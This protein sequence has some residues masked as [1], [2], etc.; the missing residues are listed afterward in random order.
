MIVSLSWPVRVLPQVQTAGQFPLDDQQFAVRYVGPTHALHIHDYAGL[1]RVG[2]REYGLCPGDLTISPAGVESA[3]HLPRAGRH[4][5][6]H[7]MQVARGRGGRGGSEA[8]GE[9]SLPLHVRL[10]SQ[11]AL[12]ID[13]VKHISWLFGQREGSAPAVL[14]QAGASAALQ[15]LLLWLS[16]RAAAPSSFASQSRAELALDRVVAIVQG[17]FQ[18]PLRMDELAAEVEVSQNYLAR[19]FRQRFG[20]TIPHYLLLRRIDHA[21]YL[22]RH[23]NMAVAAVARRVGLPDPQHF[24]KQFR[25]HVGQSPSTYRQQGS[26]AAWHRDMAGVKEGAGVRG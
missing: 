9:F 25:Q 5:C 14:A 22:L 18:Q 15:E 12:A 17:R 3:Y 2:E 11:L 26:F 10:G 20:M 21:Q 1:W 8:E 13:R 23:T 19:C 16:W 24:N 7:F 6:I 4:W